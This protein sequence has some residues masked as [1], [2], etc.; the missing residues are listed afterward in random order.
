MDANGDDAKLFIARDYLR[1]VAEVDI[2]RVDDVER[3]P[4]LAAQIL[5]SYARKFPLW[6]RRP[7]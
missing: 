1:N 7:A 5:K 6:R 3:D 2:S 4:A